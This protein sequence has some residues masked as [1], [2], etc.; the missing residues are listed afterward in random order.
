MAKI[1]KNSAFFS[2][3]FNE[4]FKNDEEKTLLS[5]YLAQNILA[6]IC[7]N[8]F[9]EHKILKNL[10]KSPSFFKE[11]HEIFSNFT[12]NNI[13]INEL[14]Q[15]AQNLHETD[16]NRLLPVIKAYENYTNTLTDNGFLDNASACL[17]LVE[18]IKKIENFKAKEPVF[19]EDFDGLSEMQLALLEKLYEKV[20]PAKKPEITALQRESYVYEDILGEI[21]GIASKIKSFCEKGAKFSEIGVF[22][23]DFNARKKL[24]GL[25]KT[26]EI[27][28]NAGISSENYENFKRTLARNFKISKILE[29]M[30]V[31][32]FSSNGFALRRRLSRSDE[33]IFNEELNFHLKNLITETLE[34]SFVRDRLL[35]LQ[36][37][38]QPFLNILFAN[39]DLLNETQKNALFQEIGA[40]KGFYTLFVEEKYLEAA[41]ITAAKFNIEK[42]TLAGV[43]GKIKG[44]FRIYKDIFSAKI[45]ADV[46]IEIAE[47]SNENKTPENDCVCV[48]PFGVHKN[49][50]YVFIPSMTENALPQKNNAANLLSPSGNEKLTEML[51]AIHPK[52]KFF[53]KTDEQH[54]SDE[55]AMFC[56]AVS[57]AQEYI[58][59]STHAFEDKK[60]CA[61]S[62]YFLQMAKN[63]IYVEKNEESS[64]KLYKNSAAA[65]QKSTKII[66]D[67]EIL[68]LNPSAISTYLKCPKK[69]YF[70]GLL[71]LKEQATFAANY[72]NIVHAVMEVFLSKYLD[73]FNKS[74]MLVLSDILFNSVDDSETA[75]Q[76]GFSQLIIDLVAATEKLALAQMRMN[77]EDAIE[78][79]DKNGWFNCA[80]ERAFCEIPF[81]FRAPEL[82]GVVFDGRIDA[83]L[84]KNGE[85]SIVDFKTG[86]NKDNDLNYALSEYGVNFFTK[87]GRTP[88]NIEDYQKKYDYQI[89]I[90]YLASQNS[91]SLKDF[92]GK[93]TKLGLEYVRP[94]NI[95][96][97]CKSDFAPADTVE[98]FKYKIL[99][100][101]KKTVVDK[102]RE[103]EEFACAND[104]QC[105][106]CTYACLCD[107]GEDE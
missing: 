30:G 88:A 45:P 95:H 14:K 71:N 2:S 61:P 91:A 27:P 107:P 68:K 26:L 21:E 49:F 90:Y 79:L 22:I 101:L 47:S 62:A 15:A 92:K 31:E 89:P 72:G 28:T 32:E 1:F 3:L 9:S 6:G 17:Y 87:T 98:T 94:K 52:Y 70:K 13:T 18:N 38:G 44:V 106:D 5:D 64:A 24:A 81:S 75:L 25:F 77:F 103:S 56:E 12:L 29:N 96:G 40:I 35:S 65:V 42:E 34:D 69:Y 100:N 63:P 53:T 102:I 50:K 39:A 7:K 85:Y 57:C 19:V 105:A 86:K 66:N 4:I 60:Q 46:L 36:E 51:A 84:E 41:S 43:L 73:S 33:E 74:A 78:E 8:L 16:K 55:W 59:L 67:D 83:M 37:T 97:G 80:P 10:L 93:V 104:F 23:R 58:S 54:L 48:L 76:A 99:E 11:L 82:G 20:L